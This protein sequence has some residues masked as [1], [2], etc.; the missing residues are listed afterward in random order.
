MQ[1]LSVSLTVSVARCTLQ[2]V[3]THG[4]S[5]GEPNWSL[6]STVRAHK[7]KPDKEVN[8]NLQS[9]TLESRV[10]TMVSHGVWH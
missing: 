8:A 3:A 6:S 7:Q 4:G 5:M 1:A 2:F 10:V 9:T